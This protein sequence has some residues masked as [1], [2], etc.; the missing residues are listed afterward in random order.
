[1]SLEKIKGIVFGVV[2]ITS[3]IVTFFFLFKYRIR[4]TLNVLF[5]G[6]W[7]YWIYQLHSKIFLEKIF[8]DLPSIHQ[9]WREGRKSSK[10]KYKEVQSIW[11]IACSL[12]AKNLSEVCENTPQLL[13]MAK[14]YVTYARAP[15]L[16]R[17]PAACLVQDCC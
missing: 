10:I 4:L 2:V 7:I 14:Y 11:V 5:L 17:D 16:C 9:G 1:M 8:Q 15:D 12:S 6:G 3:N 13:F